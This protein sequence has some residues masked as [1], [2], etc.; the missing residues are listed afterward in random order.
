MD[1]LDL[2]TNKGCSSAKGLA[3]TLDISALVNLSMQDDVEK[4]ITPGALK[5]LA[6]IFSTDLAN[7]GFLTHSDGWTLGKD[8]FI[9]PIYGSWNYFNMKNN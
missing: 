9:D 3:L 1:F 8:T 6:E 4:A 7:K 2:E 5:K